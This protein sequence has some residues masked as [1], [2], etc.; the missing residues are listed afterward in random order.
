MIR[1]AAGRSLPVAF[2][3]APAPL[4]GDIPRIMRRDHALGPTTAAPGGYGTGN[5]QPV[6]AVRRA[7]AP[8]APAQSANRTHEDAP[9]DR[10]IRIGSGTVPVT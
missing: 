9:V 6:A 7:D 10:S 4:T 5:E 2:S 3:A 8:A 1:R